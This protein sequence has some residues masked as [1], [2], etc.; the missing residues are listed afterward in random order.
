MEGKMEKIVP[1]SPLQR[2]VVE[3]VEVFKELDRRISGYDDT[4][5]A[6]VNE[7]AGMTSDNYFG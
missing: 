6:G 3:I 1:K 2:H 5:S 7:T 4:I